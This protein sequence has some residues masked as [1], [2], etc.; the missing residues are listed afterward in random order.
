MPASLRLAVL[1]TREE[2]GLRCLYHGWKF[3]ADGRCLDMPNVPPHLDFKDKIRV[4]ACP[5][6]ERGGVIW[7]YMAA[8]ARRRL[9][10]L[11]CRFP[12]WRRAHPRRSPVRRSATLR[13][14]Q[15]RADL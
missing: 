2:G 12:P 5:T 11:A 14:R 15:P 8:G 7:T 10:H 3:A 6:L 1:W 4:T 13:H 9:R